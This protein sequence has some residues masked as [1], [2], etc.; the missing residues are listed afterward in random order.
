MDVSNLDFP[1]FIAFMQIFFQE[2]NLSEGRHIRE[3][4]EI[5][6][7]LASLMHGYAGENIE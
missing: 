5:R 1:D 4:L 3:K 2:I 6:E 7:S